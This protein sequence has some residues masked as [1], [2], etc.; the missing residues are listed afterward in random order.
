MMMIMRNVLFKQCRKTLSLKNEN[1]GWRRHRPLQACGF[2]IIIISH[3]LHHH[4]FLKRSFLSHSARVRRFFRYEASPHIPE[5]CPFRVQTKL[6]HIILY[7]FSPSLSAPTCTSHPRQPPHLYQP[8]PH[9]LHSHVPHAQNTPKSNMP[10]HFSHA[11]NNQKREEK[12]FCG[13]W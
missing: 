3:H 5:H 13:N 2:G 6:I 11:L 7:T 4:L 8:T 12:K 1:R 10:H 9:F